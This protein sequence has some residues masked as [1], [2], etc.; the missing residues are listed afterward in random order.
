MQGL[1]FTSHIGMN[2]DIWYAFNLKTKCM[3][4]VHMLPP[5]PRITGCSP[6]STIY[7]RKN[8]VLKINIYIKDSVKHAHIILLNKKE[9]EVLITASSEKWDT[10]A[11]TNPSMSEWIHSLCSLIFPAN[12]NTALRFSHPVILTYKSRSVAQTYV[13][14]LSPCNLPG[15]HPKTHTQQGSIAKNHRVMGLQY[16]H[17]ITHT[18][19]SVTWKT[20][21]HILASV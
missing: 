5:F 13:D 14:W 11:A 17:K 12:K 19:I 3:F 4:R 6:L 1:P 10:T 20:Q 2:K 18:E 16:Q 9:K 21:K 7:W 15:F 8:N